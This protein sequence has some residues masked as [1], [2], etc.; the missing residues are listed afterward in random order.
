M[1]Y[2]TRVR[3][4]RSSRAARIC[5]SA[6]LDKSFGVAIF[7]ADSEADAEKFM[8]EDPAIKGGVFKAELHPMR[9]ALLGK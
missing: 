2:E 8:N 3:L 9:I 7:R 4:H 6:C 5:R 1:K